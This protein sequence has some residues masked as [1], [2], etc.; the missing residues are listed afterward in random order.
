VTVPIIGADIVEYNPKHDVHNMT[1]MVAAKLVK[2]IGG[3][4]LKNTPQVSSGKN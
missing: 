1:A 3:M 2:E 4:I